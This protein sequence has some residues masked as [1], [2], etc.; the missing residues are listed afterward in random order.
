MAY[1][2][3]NLSSPMEIYHIQVDTKMPKLNA[4]QSSTEKYLTE[5]NYISKMS[6]VSRQSKNNISYKTDSLLWL[7][8][9]KMKLLLRLIT[10]FRKIRS[11]YPFI[12][13]LTSL[14]NQF[15]NKT[16]L[17]L[18]N[19]P[20]QGFLTIDA[21]K[22]FQEIGGDLI[23]VNYW[24]ENKKFSSI[25]P[26]Y[27][28]LS[29]P[30][31]LSKKDDLIDILKE[32]NIALLRYLNTNPSIKIIC[33]SNRMFE[34]SQFIDK[35]R[36]IPFIDTDI[37]GLTKNIDPR[38]PRGYTSMTLYK[39]LAMAV[40]FGYKKIFILGMDNTYPRTLYSGSNNEILI[41]EI[42][43]GSNE[44]VQDI[45]K[46]YASIGDYLIE[47]AYLFKDL[48]FFPKHNITNLD[49]YSLTTAFQKARSIEHGLELLT[50]E[51]ITSQENI[52]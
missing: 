11:E 19:G 49:P 26:S 29:D 44:F 36:L 34:I 7:L 31:T 5:V 22:K 25:T 38:F 48:D 45:T 17:V 10:F 52:N 6:I 14:K 32:K 37:R 28:V 15:P 9:N 33:P 27:I 42:H 2:A 50:N 3:E 41:H 1:K 40:F 12:K 4:D 20:S 51:T 47:C 13:Q 21:I 30:N 23:V 43:S 8:R 35:S 39:A 24:H 46:M 16:A 18:G